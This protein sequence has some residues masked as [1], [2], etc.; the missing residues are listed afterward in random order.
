MI[1]K[2]SVSSWIIKLIS[3]YQPV[4]EPHLP[5]EMLKGTNLKEICQRNIHKYFCNSSVRSN[6][7]MLK[8]L[9]PVYNWI[10]K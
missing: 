6:K 1:Y 5:A 4:D 8:I 9:F 10:D 7:N 2:V 3:E